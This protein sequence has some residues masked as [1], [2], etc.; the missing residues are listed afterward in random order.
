MLE[1]LSLPEFVTGRIVVSPRDFARAAKNETIKAIPGEPDDTIP[2][3]DKLKINA[4]R[5]PGETSIHE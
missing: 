2:R 1:S 5:N 3:W 4:G